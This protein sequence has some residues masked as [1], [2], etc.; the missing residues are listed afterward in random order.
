MTHLVI[1]E[2]NA[3]A[4]VA[5][6]EAAASYFIGALLARRPSVRLTV[7]APY[8][9]PAWEAALET[10]DGAVF[11][12]SDAAWAVDAAEAAPLRRA[13]E[14]VFAAGTPVWGSCN[15]MQL[16]SVVLGGA[17]RASPNGLEVGLARGLELT[18][19]GARHPMMRGRENGFA[20]ACIHRD[21]VSKLPE[22]AQALAGNAHS[23]VQA[24]AF[25]Q[26]GVDFWGV[27]YHPEC[28]PSDIA[29]VVRA[30]G[31]DPALSGDPEDLGRAD[32]DPAAAA[33]L[34]ANASDLAFSARTEELAN[35]MAHVE[36]ARAGA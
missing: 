22:G 18:D 24:M 34:G 15:G 9:N 8:A 23:A 1:F 26:G 14:T 28:A 29:R 16:A 20:S 21:E 19:A 2:S 31:I 33:R 12:G 36:A 13:M 7:V 30:R 17:V 27:Q 25:A 6:G 32:G 4:S 3:P 35:W 5:R 10:G 11:T